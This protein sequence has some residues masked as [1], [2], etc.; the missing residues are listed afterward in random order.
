VKQ[1]KG[2]NSDQTGHPLRPFENK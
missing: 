2:L 1:R